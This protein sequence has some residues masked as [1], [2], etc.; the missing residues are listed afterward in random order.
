MEREQAH[1][2]SIVVIADDAPI[3]RLT[4]LACER[5]G[6]RVYMG[7]LRKTIEA[8]SSHPV[9]LLTE[10]TIGYRSVS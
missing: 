5:A 7:A 1:T 2:A 9:M 4:R 10:S 6:F 8:D 3:R